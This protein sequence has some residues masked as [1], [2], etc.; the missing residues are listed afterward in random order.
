MTTSNPCDLTRIAALPT[1]ACLGAA[2]IRLEEHRPRFVDDE[3]AKVISAVNPKRKS[4]L[5]RDLEA[6][7]R[8]SEI[9]RAAYAAIDRAEAILDDP[10]VFKVST[11]LADWIASNRNLCALR[12]GVE[13]VRELVASDR[14]DL[15]AMCS[16]H[17]DLIA[18]RFEVLQ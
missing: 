13:N 2:G 18:S 8:R 12:I 16:E 9:V 4:K 10:P 17:V 14:L 15:T 3:L 5:E 1:T 7:L 11:S 6:S